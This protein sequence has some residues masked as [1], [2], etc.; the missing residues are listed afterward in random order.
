MN[1][2]LATLILLIALP[3]AKEIIGYYP[4]WQWYDRSKLAA[5]ENL[6]FSKISIVN[7]AFFQTDTSG[8]ILV[9]HHLLS[10]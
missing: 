8:N 10:I 4:S 3:L 1:S 2:T 5:P 6:D 7:F 9:F